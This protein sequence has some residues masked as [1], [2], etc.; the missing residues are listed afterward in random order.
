MTYIKNII[1]KPSPIN[2]I[3]LPS[4]E[5]WTIFT[6]ASGPYKDRSVGHMVSFKDKTLVDLG[7]GSPEY[8]DD[9]QIVQIDNKDLGFDLEKHLETN[10]LLDEMNKDL[11]KDTNPKD[12]IGI[13][14][15]PFSCVPANVIGEIALGLMEGARKYGRHNYR[16][17][18]VR[19]SVYYD[20]AMRHLNAWYEGEDIDKDSGLSHISKAL[21]CLVVLRDA[22]MNDNWND[23]RPPKVKNQNWVAEMNQKAAEIIEKYPDSVDSYTEKNSSKIIDA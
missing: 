4:N 7:F 2:Y 1:G 5:R 17:M 10:R 18:G 21:S 6:V 22:I 23:D 20:A 19:A 12:A 15:V 13:K 3:N 14:K 11:T 16:I 8:E 9:G